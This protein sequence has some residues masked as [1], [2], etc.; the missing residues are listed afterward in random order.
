MKKMMSIVPNFLCIVLVTNLICSGA[1]FAEIGVILKAKGEVSLTRGAEAIEVKRKGKVH[2]GDLL[3]TGPGGQIFLRMIDK[4]KMIIRPNSEVILESLR[5]DKKSTDEQKTS[6]LKGA[7]RAVSG[8]IAERT[9]EN[10]TFSAGTATIGIRG[11]D[12]EVAII[13]DGSSDRAGIYNYVYEGSTEM[14]LVTGESA[15]VEK[16]QSGFTPKDP[17]PGEALL[18]VLDDRPAFLS[19]SGFD[20]LMQQ[21]TNPRVPGIR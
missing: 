8:G 4:S 21:L 18:Q 19:S 2:A 13:R 14:A 1:A 12:I 20:T 11:T 6:V 17:T 15:V 7:I 16:E 10:V 3:I 9:K 5:Y